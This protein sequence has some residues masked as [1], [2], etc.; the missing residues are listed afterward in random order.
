MKQLSIVFT[1]S[2]KKFP[3]GSWL[4]R[5]W[6][7]KEYSHVS[8]EVNVSDWGKGYYQS[9]D[10]K[11]NY[12]HERFFLKKH[13]II[14]KYTINITNKQ[15]LNIKKDCWRDSGGPYGI[16]QNLGIALVD[17]FKFFNKN[18]VNPWKTGKN[19]SELIYTNVLK[20]ID[21]ELKYKPD[22][23]KPHHIEDIL[24]KLGYKP[25]NINN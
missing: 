10:G 7:R 3:I 22:T 6:T 11:I 4:I 18:I 14:K 16:L 9:N 1:K 19:C 21:P 2:K 25:D 8:R 23:I 20:K 5:F 13:I 24:L 15:E 12:E 17:I